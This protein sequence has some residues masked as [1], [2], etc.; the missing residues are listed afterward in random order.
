MKRDFHF[1]YENSIPVKKKRRDNNK[2]KP[3]PP[4]NA[5]H[6]PSA[7]PQ[8]SSPFDSTSKSS[9]KNESKKQEIKLD[10]NK[11]NLKPVEELQ[12]EDNSNEDDVKI[13]TPKPHPKNSKSAKKFRGILIAAAA[14]LILGVLFICAGMMLK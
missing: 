5:K 6:H 3:A 4:I 7:A 14:L 10:I 1:K 11:F 13:Y 2:P 9:V 8:E 12:S